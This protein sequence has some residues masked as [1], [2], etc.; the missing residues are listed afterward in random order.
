MERRAP[1]DNDEYYGVNISDEEMTPGEGDVVVLAS[2]DLH[3][4]ERVTQTSYVDENDRVESGGWLK[5]LGR[6]SKIIVEKLKTGVVRGDNDLDFVD[7]ALDLDSGHEIFD[8]FFASFSMILV[9]EIGDETFIIAAPMAMRHPKSIVLSGALRALFV[10][11]D[12]AK[13]DIK[14]AYKHCSYRFAGKFDHLVNV[15][16]VRLKKNLKLD[17]RKQQSDS[18]FPDFVRLYIWSPLS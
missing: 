13:F 14:E 10:M 16:Y 6:R 11:T 18:S 4:C 15:K 3:E 8:A 12:C 1:S 9:S 7:V 2:P 5:D 17:R